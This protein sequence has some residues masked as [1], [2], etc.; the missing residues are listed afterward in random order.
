MS[1]VDIPNDGLI[2]LDYDS[3]GYLQPQTW[4]VAVDQNHQRSDPA[5]DMSALP[6]S[7]H[8]FDQPVPHDP[9]L[10]LDWH[11]QQLPA[12]LQYRQDDP[13][14]A[15]QYTTGSYAMS[16]QSSPVDF[17][18]QN[19]MSSS[20]LDG[21]YLPLS[22][23][24]DMVPFQYQDFQT[25]LMTFNH[26]L[27]DVASY[28]APQNVVDSSSPT[29]TYLEVRS[30]GSS[31]SETGWN[32]I[33]PRNSMDFFPEQGIFI[34]PT[35][36][37]HDRSLSES[38]YSTSL[39]SSFVEVSNPANS[40]TSDTNLDLPY[41]TMKRRVSFDHTSHGSQSP[42]AVSPV[43]MVRPIP[44]PN[45]KS[46]SPSRSPASQSASSFSA[47]PPSRKPSRRS[48]IAAKTTETKVRK[49][50]QSGKPDSEK[51]VGKRK[52]P[53]KPD[54]RKQAS[55]IRKLRAC[56]RCKFL[57]KTVSL[58]I[59][60]YMQ[61]LLTVHSVTRANRVRVASPRMRGYGRFHAPGLTSKISGTL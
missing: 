13:S 42:T 10:M 54:Q 59:R 48:P 25:D 56:L 9:N 17:M 43:A 35:Q 7:G 38:S 4:P 50:S 8:S 60:R 58:C 3:K 39:G 11:F 47:S 40:P 55:E 32:T 6:N 12:N 31:S 22:A 21:S 52:G 41:S 45:K 16:M 34:N 46:A 27:P 5:R 19:Q 44:V 49:H 51:R 28:A 2:G 33:E 24:V 30:L 29:D 15:P 57:K 36:T 18:S 26:G 53:L 23:P 1:N 37:L 20:L 61:H 14:S